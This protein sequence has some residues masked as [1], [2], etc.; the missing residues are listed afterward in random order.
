MKII[1]TAIPEVKIIEPKIFFDERGYFTESFNK[2][3]YKELGMIHEFVQDNRSYSKRGVLRG[4]HF[5]KGEASQAKLV[6]VLKGA[7]LD[8]AVDIRK[9]SK[10]FGKW[11]STVISDKNFLQMYIPRGFAHGFLILS[12]EAEFF[13]KCDNYYSPKDEG[14]V[15]FDDPDL[16][17][18]WQIDVSDLI[19]SEKDRN[20]PMLKDI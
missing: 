11:V 1:E 4:L 3:V 20:L 16:A 9:G 14:G 10:T 6:S 5:Q 15:R 17:I 13:Y 18:D 19:L 8:V 7:V 2:R 12:E